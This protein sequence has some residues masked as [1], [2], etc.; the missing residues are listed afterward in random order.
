VMFSGISATSVSDSSSYLTLVL[1]QE[2]VSHQLKNRVSA[3]VAEGV[4]YGISDYPRFHG[5]LTEL[6]EKRKELS[7]LNEQIRYIEA[8]DEVVIADE[9]L[10]IWGNEFAHI[11]LRS[12]EKVG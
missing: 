12:G 10:S 5:G 11:T 8:D 9:L 4:T 1:S 7:Q 3:N 2:P 6:L